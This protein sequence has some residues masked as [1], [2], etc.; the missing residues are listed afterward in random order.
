MFIIINS[1]YLA[2]KILRFNPAIMLLGIYLAESWEICVKGCMLIVKFC[3][4]IKYWNTS[5][6]SFYKS[7]ITTAILPN[8]PTLKFGVIKASINAHTYDFYMLAGKALF[9]RSSSGAQGK[10]ICDC[11]EHALL[12]NDTRTR[13]QDGKSNHVKHISSLSLCR[14]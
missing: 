13:C 11:L 9:H 8:K 5:K 14:I 3:V 6:W 4:I 1:I 10:G 2:S 12:G 7:T